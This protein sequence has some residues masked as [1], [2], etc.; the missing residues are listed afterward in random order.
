MTLRARGLT[1]ATR[2]GRSLIASVDV[3]FSRGAVG[4]VLGENGAGKST[5]LD[6]LAGVRARTSGSVML[7]G[8]DVH[9][10]S[11]ST[12]ARRIASMA[13]TAPFT[14][15]SST[16]ERIAHGL[17]PRRGRRSLLD[18]DAVERVREVARTLDVEAHLLMP[19]GSLSGGERKRVE[20]A[21]TL[22]DDEPRVVILDEPFAGI[23]IARRPLIV[24]VLRA[25]AHKGVAV[26]VSVHEI[27][28]ALAL[29]DA[30]VGLREGRV[31][32]ASHALDDTFVHD[33]F[34]VEA[35]IVRDDTHRGALFTLR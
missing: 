34:G 24:E 9:A 30:F 12:R 15:L 17:V 16:M 7:D 8:D 28:I 35:R 10:L 11:P 6:A 2:A 32:R 13:Q 19:L 3:E 14:P 22:V 33:V 1:V 26:V 18:S 29:G 25:R 21:R 31:V 5:L 27:D 4:V 23:D 20:I